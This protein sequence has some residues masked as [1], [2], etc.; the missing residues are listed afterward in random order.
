MKGGEGVEYKE[1]KEML[2]EQM[3]LL[4]ERSKK[5]DCTNEDLCELT[6]GMIALARAI[7]SGY[8]V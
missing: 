7:F 8:P 1:M 6:R 5:E 2:S 4:A 3:E